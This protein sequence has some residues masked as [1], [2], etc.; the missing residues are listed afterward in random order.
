MKPRWRKTLVNE[1][2]REC[3]KCLAFKTWDNFHT[4]TKGPNNKA[5]EC[6]ICTYARNQEWAN[7]SGWDRKKYINKR[8]LNFKEILVKEFGSCCWNCKQV[9]PPEVFDFHHLDPKQKDFRVSQGDNSLENMRQEAL[10]CALLCANC[11][12]IVH[13]SKQLKLEKPTNAN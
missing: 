8:R 6:R 5:Q 10:K 11:H 2:G 4:R 1:I 12:R 3:T 13:R 7:R 9:F